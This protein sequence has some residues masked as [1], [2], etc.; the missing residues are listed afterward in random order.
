MRL[1]MT[2][3]STFYISSNFQDLV[4]ESFE[5]HHLGSTEKQNLDD[6]QPLSYIERELMGVSNDGP[7][8]NPFMQ[9][10][11]KLRG[12]QFPIDKDAADRIRDFGEGNL[13]F[14]QLSIGLSLNKFNN[15]HFSLLVLVL[16][17]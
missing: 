17:S 3:V 2:N 9:S 7:A 13:D 12:V 8:M 11:Q 14:V 1:F 5:K 10:T 4:L 16:R 15:I 6:S